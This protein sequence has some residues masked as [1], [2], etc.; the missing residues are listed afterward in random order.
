MHRAGHRTHDLGHAQ[1]VSSA[2]GGAGWWEGWWEE[3]STAS[4][5]SSRLLKVYIQVQ[6]QAISH[7][8]LL[9]PCLGEW[10][11]PLSTPA[12]TWAS[13]PCLLSPLCASPFPYES[14]S[15]SPLTS[16]HSAFTAPSI[17]PP[18][19]QITGLEPCSLPPPKKKG[20]TCP[21]LQAILSSCSLGVI[22]L[23]RKTDLIT[24][25]LKNPSRFPMALRIKSTL[26]KL[27]SL[28]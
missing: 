8:P 25:L 22:S 1:D 24:P 17:P 7:S 12:K 26:A 18:R 9:C 27:L 5:T 14:L 20:P 23:H 28:F 19:C 13:P 21:P 10:R 3:V 2:P 11:G 16:P 6:H 15:K 4:G